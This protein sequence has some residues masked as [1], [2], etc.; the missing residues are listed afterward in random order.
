MNQKLACP[1][2]TWDDFREILDGRYDVSFYKPEKAPHILD[3]GANVGA[4]TVWAKN[5]WPDATVFC[6]EPHPDNV[7][8]LRQNVGNLT[9]VSIHEVAIGDAQFNHDG[10]SFANLHVGVNTGCHSLFN[11]P[12]GDQHMDVE[13]I[14]V[15]TILPEDLPAC[16]VLK[17][18]TEGAEPLILFRYKYL[19][20]VK[21][22]AFE[23]HR[24]KDK[25]S[26][27][28][29]LAENGFICVSDEQWHTH[30]GEMKWFRC[31][32]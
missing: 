9:N 20:A 32:T 1:Q 5:K 27:G 18:D 4:Y 3:C 13:P 28:S 17:M 31:A 2:E 24:Y 7:K 23:W 16:D 30:R 29:F 14:T 6:Y 19:H 21:S 12:G 15:E 22:I 10:K 11:P 26:I 8:L 25:W